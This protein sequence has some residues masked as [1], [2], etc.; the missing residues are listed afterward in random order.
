MDSAIYRRQKRY[1]INIGQSMIIHHI[2]HSTNVLCH[3]SLGGRTKL[4][5]KF[6]IISSTLP[7]SLIPG[8]IRATVAG[9]GHP[10]RRIAQPPIDI[11]YCNPRLSM[12]TRYCSGFVYTC[13]DVG[14]VENIDATN[15]NSPRKSVSPDGIFGVVKS[16]ITISATQRIC[17]M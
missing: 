9:W 14:T 13:S 12:P 17:D 8:S 10:C 11:H 7:H 3:G 16:P 5:E 6:T 4:K 1:H 15:C 2:I